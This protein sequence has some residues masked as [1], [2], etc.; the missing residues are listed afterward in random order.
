MDDPGRAR[1]RARA[2]ERERIYLDVANRCVLPRPE[3]STGWV[4]WLLIE[5]FPRRQEETPRFSLVALF[6][7]NVPGSIVGVP[8]IEAHN[9][10]WRYLLPV[11]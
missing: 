1:R 5:A 7:L 8:R 2:R 11:Q 9:N 10:A 3:Y 4:V 6:F